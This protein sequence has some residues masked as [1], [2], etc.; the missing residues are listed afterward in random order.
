MPWIER[1]RFVCS[2]TEAVMSALRV[3]R[4]ATGR[5]IILKFEGCYHGHVDSLLVKAGSGLAGESASDSAGVSE[6][7]ARQTLTI[8]L[9]D[10]FA[11]E[12]IFRE[13]G[14]EIAAVILEPMPAN[15]GLL[16]QRTEFIQDVVRQAKRHGA[17]VIF[18]EVISGFRV[19]FGGMA[20]R[21]GI[22]PDLVTYG[23]V[24]G[25]GLAVGAYAGRKEYMD[26]VAPAGKVYQAGTLSANP[27]SMRT[28]LATVKKLKEHKVH[29][30][31]EKRTERF[32]KDLSLVLNPRFCGHQFGFVFWIHPR[33]EEPLRT[34]SDLP[35][36]M[37][38]YYKP[39]FH[40]LLERGVYMAPSGYE[41]GFV[42]LAHTDDIL[43]ATLGKVHEAVSELG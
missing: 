26:L 3:A 14:S 30:V 39:L 35:P 40:R 17:L 16:L 29:D 2:G 37:G 1:I 43:D 38:E 41:V 18:D 25:G 12:S 19:A 33:T 21:L 34:L 10:E 15:Y 32:A 22:T 6:Q 9:N 11:L 7:T 31:L 28:G 27:L 5:S 4:A 36:N 13:R 24:L 8:P 42:S 23:K 20:E